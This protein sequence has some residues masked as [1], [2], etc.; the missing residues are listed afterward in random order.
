VSIEF[1]RALQILGDTITLSV[2]FS[3]SGAGSGTAAIAC[4]V[5]QVM[6][7]NN[8]L[9]DAVTVRVQLCKPC[10]ATLITFV[11]GHLEELRGAAKILPYTLTC[12]V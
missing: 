2:Q 4:M 11:T 9:F 5:E 12:R 10:A 3:E 1:L 8:V 6:C 7:T